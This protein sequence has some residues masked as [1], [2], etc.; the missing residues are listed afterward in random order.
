MPIS[1]FNRFGRQ[2]IVEQNLK[3]TEKRDFFVTLRRLAGTHGVLPGSMMIT[4]EIEVSDKI[5]ASGGF[6]D[7]R[8]GTYMGHLVAVKSMKIAEQ[9]KLPKIRRVSI[10]I[11]LS[12][13]WDAV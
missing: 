3:A 5:F 8:T 6:A 4:E 2:G 11:F 9:D 10:S 12:A 1:L 13:T 7:V